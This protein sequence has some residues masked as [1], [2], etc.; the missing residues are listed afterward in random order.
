MAVE[1]EKTTTPGQT[2]NDA[3]LVADN[4]VRAFGGLRAVDVDHFE[5]TSRSSAAR[6]LP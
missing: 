5:T 1:T 6:S 3:I 4:V 2:K